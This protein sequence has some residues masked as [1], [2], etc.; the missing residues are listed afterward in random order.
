MNTPN[1]A[2]SVAPEPVSKEAEEKVMDLLKARPSVAPGTYRWIYLWQLPIRVTHW[3]AAAALVLLA[4]TGYYI[5]QPYLMTSGEPSSHFLMGWMRFLHLSAAGVLVAAAMLRVYWLFMGNRY[6]SWKALFPFKKKDWVNTWRMIKA[7]VAVRPDEAPHYVGHN[8][9]QQIFYTLFYGLAV[10]EV[11]TG[12][13]L[14]GLSNPGGLIY[15]TFSWIGPA[16]GGWQVA[17]FLHHA[18]LWVFVSFIPVHIYLVV[19]AAVL[20]REGTI[21]SIFTGG[22]FIHDDVDFEDA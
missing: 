18:L 22:R 7:Y 10:V 11:A 4:V 3:F 5:G 15:R 9:L 21:T 17:R 6:E 14:Y 13:A 8:P 16:M 20:D 12:F 2:P 19:R 1:T